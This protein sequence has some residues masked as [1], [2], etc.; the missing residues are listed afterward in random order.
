MDRVFDYLL[1][2]ADFSGAIADFMNFGETAAVAALFNNL[3]FAPSN[4]SYSN[5]K[6]AS[7]ANSALIQAD[8]SD[9]NLY[10]VDFN[11]AVMRDIQL[12]SA[13]SIQDAVLPN[14]VSV[15]DENLI[16][17]GQP[18]CNTSL[19]ISWTLRNM[20]VTAIMSNKGERKC[21][22]TLQSLSSGANMYQRVNLS[23]KWNSS[24]W[25]YS[26]AILRA[27]MSI[28]IS[29]QLR[30]FDNNNQ[31]LAR[32]TLNSNGADTSLLLSEEMRE[33]EVF[34]DFSALGNHSNLTNY[35]FEDIRV[36]IIYGTYLEFLRVIPTIPANA[37]WTQNGVTVAGDN[38]TNGQVVAGVAAGKRPG[39][40]LD[41]LIC[42]ID[43]L[44]D[45]WTDSLIICDM[46][47]RRVVL[48]SRRSGTT[49]GEILIN[50]IDCW[51]LAIDDQRY[52]Y[53]SN[54]KKHE[55]RRY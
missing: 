4:F 48:W 19:M 32:Q 13:V 1:V 15:H 8:F 21:Q 30:G 5:I 24:S 35:S 7:F 51:G 34:V 38:T 18:D 39:S 11:G 46:G 3:Y 37:K 49:Q 16:K 10:K 41:Q 2:A 12:E 26:Q 36:F 22:F 28:G 20:N 6:R 27:N 53:V 31:V 40:P 42:P 47:N 45:K 43:V 52:L 14:G 17:N 25:S 33:L 9:A 54:Y 44:I 29:M 23:E 55:A 50:N